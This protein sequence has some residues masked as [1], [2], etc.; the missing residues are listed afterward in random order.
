[1]HSPPPRPSRPTPG[2]LPPGRPGDCRRSASSCRSSTRSGTSRRRS[3]AVLGQDY[4]GPARGGP[5]ARARARTAPTRSRGASRRATRACAP[6]RTR[7]GRTP[8]AL[9][10]AIAASGDVDV[11]VRVDGH[12]V[13]DRD[14]V[15]T[16]VRPAGGDRRGQRRRPHGRRGRHGVRAGGR[17]GD[18]LAA[19]R[20]GRPVPH[21]RRGR[22][23][24]HRLP[25]RVPARVADA[26]G[27]LRRPRSSAPRTGSSTTGSARPAGWSGSRPRCGCATGRGRPC[28]RSPGSTATTA[29]GAASSPGS[30]R[31]TINAR[32]LAPPAVLVAASS[33]GAVGRLRLVPA[34]A[35]S[36]RLPRRDDRRRAQPQGR[37]AAATGSGCRRSCRPCTC[38][39]AGASS[40]ARA[41]SSPGVPSAAPRR[42]RDAARRRR[43]AATARRRGPPAAGDP[44]AH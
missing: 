35:R 14:Y 2:R 24:R 30:T 12:G 33:A 38:R 25:R 40:P 7:P 16:A 15:R 9:N 27:R 22:A 31:G 29:A 23:G 26:A 42:P 20:R 43:P 19:R 6:C 34:V 32:Y 13:L 37:A 5:R 18:D 17:R 1:M 36:R 21:R 41:R 3:A 11:V 28:G 44:R 4:D 10:A 8:D 39:G